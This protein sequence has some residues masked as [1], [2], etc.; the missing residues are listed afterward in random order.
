MDSE[1][2]PEKILSLI[3]RFYSGEIGLGDLPDSE[4]I[5]NLYHSNEEFRRAFHSDPIIRKAIEKFDLVNSA[6]PDWDG[7]EF[8]ETMKKKPG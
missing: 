3:R 2:D 4:L 8:I 5:S 7:K 6:C 1:I